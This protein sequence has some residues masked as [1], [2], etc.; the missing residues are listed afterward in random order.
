MLA[1]VFVPAAAQADAGAQASV[2]GG[3]I[4]KIADFPS[5][6]FIQA[7]TKREGFACSA[8]VISP[9]VIL[10]AG[11][12]AEDIDAG[13][14]TPA[15]EYQIATGLLNPHQVK[16]SEVLH[17]TS[18]HV[19]P[20]FDP[21]LLKSDAAVLILATP[22][23]APP[24]PLATSTDASLYKGGANATLVGW[25]LRHGDATAEPRRLRTAPTK[26]QSA[27]SCKS[28]THSFDPVY[29]PALQMCTLDP[30]H[31]ATGDC[32]GDSGG[33]L[34]ANRPDGSP[35]EIGITSGVAPNCD[36]KRPNIFTRADLVSSWASEWVA[37]TETGAPPPSLKARLPKMTQLA[38]GRLLFGSLSHFFGPSFTLSKEPNGKCKKVGQTRTSC[39]VAWRF[40]P[41]IYFGTFAVYYVLRRNTVVAENRFTIR[42][43]NYACVIDHGSY[44][45]CPFQTA[46]G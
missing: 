30:P 42:R 35:V 32:F 26:I 6:A 19:F 38:A 4:A 2:I 17:V 16:T 28:G 45:A 39:Q 7:G 27:S 5:L 44:R 36:T 34:I 43:A 24:I 20:K 3:R 13:K 14:L 1:T 46:H 15:S 11:H 33:P 8:T 22:T 31:R 41:D 29:S 18:T 21:G 10:T 12:C 9:R 23:T 40:G 37:A 25:G